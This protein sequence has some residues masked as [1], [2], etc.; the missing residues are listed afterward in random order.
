MNTQKVLEH[1]RGSLGG[2]RIGHSIILMG[3]RRAACKK[4]VFSPSFTSM[5]AIL[6]VLVAVGA[7]HAQP[8]RAQCSAED[9]A[10][11]IT[12]TI[13]GSL[14][15]TYPCG[16]CA[17]SGA[18]NAGIAGI[19]ASC[20]DGAANSG[21]NE[22]T[23]GATC[24]PQCPGNPG[25]PECAAQ[26]VAH[27][28]KGTA[29]MQCPVTIPGTTCSVTCD[30][31][32]SGGGLMTCATVGS[33]TAWSTVTCGLTPTCAA[34]TFE[35]S[36]TECPAGEEGATCSVECAHQVEGGGTITCTT[37]GGELAWSTIT[38]PSPP[39]QATYGC[40]CCAIA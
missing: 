40:F 32:F 7:L 21:W 6:H 26:Q 25:C 16:F 33:E 19:R 12:Q 10:T 14:Y 35:N 4:P 29:A 2:T 39:P 38:C 5:H 23:N 20:V 27:S 30:T 18:C 37:E 11:C 34:T 13:P 36:D 31:G 8:A 22:L 17:S 9:C 1:R 3:A 28:D 24:A 15:G